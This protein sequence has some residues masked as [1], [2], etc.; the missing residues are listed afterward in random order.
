MSNTEKIEQRQM[1]AAMPL[2]VS[3]AVVSGASAVAVFVGVA[4]SDVS[5]KI[6]KGELTFSSPSARAN[7]L[8]Q[9]HKGTVNG[10][11]SGAALLVVGVT[12][13]V[14]GFRCQ[15]GSLRRVAVTSDGL[16]IRF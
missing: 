7:K 12:L 11:V 3:S 10:L 4:W 9:A 8:R 5:D 14:I 15:T 13:L 6:V 2:I 1:K 16:Q